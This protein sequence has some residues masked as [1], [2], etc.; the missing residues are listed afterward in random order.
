MTGSNL[1]HV[2]HI[3]R[4]VCVRKG[5]ECGP[6]ASELQRGG[7]AAGTGDQNR[8]LTLLDGRE[9]R[10]EVLRKPKGMRTRTVAVTLEL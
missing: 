3:H 10:Y 1:E 5:P 2:V 6:G 9:E 7:E 8:R 4:H